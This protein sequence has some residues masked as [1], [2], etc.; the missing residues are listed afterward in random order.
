MTNIKESKIN[1]IQYHSALP[2]FNIHNGKKKPHL[3]LKKMKAKVKYT[4]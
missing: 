2:P 4:K 1:S 3:I